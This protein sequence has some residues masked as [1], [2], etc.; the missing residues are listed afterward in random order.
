MTTISNKILDYIAKRGAEDR[1]IDLSTVF[2]GTGLTYTVTSSNADVAAV[3]IEDGK[4]V[5]D[6]TDVLGHTD[7]KITATDANGHSMT[8]NV[9]VRVAGENAYTIAVLPDTQDYTNASREYIF[10]GMMNWLVDNKDSLDLQFVIH[11]GD[12]T[13][14]NSDTSHWP[15]AEPAI[16][17]LDGKIP[18]SLLPGNHDQNT[19]NAANWSTT[20]LDTRFSPDKQAATNPDTFGGVYDM[21]PNRSANNYHTFTAP[22]GTKWM[23]LSL[24]FG[25]RADV[26]RWADEVI[27]AH[28]DHRVILANH[29][30]MTWA[31]RHDATGAPLYDEGTGYDYGIGN[32]PMQ[33]TDGE[34]MYRQL[35]QKHSNVTFTFSGHIFGD[36][37]ETLKSHDQFG[38][39][40]YQMMVNYQNG[41]STEITGN[42]GQASGSNGGNGA[43]RLLT[44]DPDSGAVYTSTYFSAIDDYLDSVRGD[45]ELDRDGLTGPYR[46][47]EEVLYLDVGTPALVAIAKAGNDQVVTAEAGAD[48]AL[49]VLDGGRTLNPGADAGLDYVWTDAKGHVVATGATPSLDLTAG[50]HQFTLTV[51]DS[52]GRVST[53]AV[54]VIV[55][56]QNT[57]L[58]DNFNDGNATGWALPGPAVNVTTGTPASFGIAALPQAEGGP[59]AGN[60]TSVPA[61]SAAQ[62]M[63]MQP[64]SPVP[65]GT[66]VTSYT[67]AYDIL[68]PSTGGNWFSFFQ[69]DVTNGSDAELFLNKRG[70]TGG[71]GINSD[72]EGSFAYNAW[73]RVVFTITDRG[74]NDVLIDKY[75]NGVKVGDT[76]MTGS[77]AAR[78]AVDLSKGALLFADNDGETSQ[79][80]VSSF[81]FTDKVLTS[82]EIAALGGVKAGGILAEQPTPNSVQIDF[83]TPARAD[84]WGNA[85]VTAAQIGTSVGNFLVKGTAASRSTTE[86]G[87][88]L[89]EGRLFQQ[90][91]SA[92]NVLVWKGAGSQTWKDYEFEATLHATDNDGIGVVFYHQDPQNH[93][94]VALDAETNTRTL[95][96]V[97]NGVTTVLA[98]DNGG[99]PW[100]RDFQLKVVVAGNQISVFLDGNSLFGEV[101]DAAPLTGGTVGFYSN[102]QRSSQFDN[103]TVNKIALT[104]HAADIDRPVDLDGDGKV[105]VTL[106]AAGSYGLS[107]ITSF[108][109]TDANGNIVASGETVQVE[110]AAV[111]Q[112]LTLT[113]TDAAGKT[114]TDKI[115]IDAVSQDRVLLS[116][117]FSGADFAAWTIV[118]E[119]ES[120]GVG[121]DGKSSQWELR[122]GALVQL[123]DIKSRQLTWSGASNS[124]PWKKGWSPLGDGVNVLRKGTYAL[125][126]DPAA[127]DWK[128]YAVEATIQS[129]DNGALGLLFYY[130]DANNYYKLELDANGDYDRTP[131][132]GAGSLFQL[133]QVKNGVESYLNQF[134]AKYTPGK[135]L[136]LRV[137]VEA[138]KIQAYVDGLA[139]FAYAIEDHAQTKGTVGL[140]SWDSAGVKFDNVKVYDLSQD[141]MLPGDRE[142][143]VGTPGDDILTGTEGADLIQG[144]DGDDVITAGAGN[145]LVQGGAGDD[146]LDGGAGN[147][148]LFGGEGDDEL[149]GGV[150]DDLLSG[151]AGDDLLNGGA[152][153]DTADYSDD[154][155]GVR[156]DLARGEAS[157]E[158]SGE[159]ELVSIE[160]VIGGAGNDTLIGD[161][162]ANLLRGGAGNDVLNGG[163]GN[164][165]LDGGAGNDTIDGGEG[166]DVLDLSGATG[167]V[168]ADFAAGIVSGAGIG[169]DS[170]R[171]IE[172]LQFGAGNDVVTGGNGNEAFNGGAGD[173]K[174]GG[175]T[176]NDT[177]IGGE[178]NDT[179]DGGSGHDLIDGG[180]GNDVIK[181]GSG[182]DTIGG[183]DGDDLI[184]AGSGD[185]IV[186]G[187]A[188]NDTIDG[189]SGDDRIEGGAG[190][191]VLTGGSGKDSFVFAPGFGND[192]IADFRTTGSSADVL[193]FSSAIFADFDAAIAAAAQVGAAT[194]F[195]IDADTS[196]TLEGVK[197]SALAADDFRFV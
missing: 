97:Q 29:S 192:R 73:N 124:D 109:W 18:Y 184:D 10:K 115:T 110:L 26:L 39:P 175:G 63:I 191:D 44:I 7:L 61:L 137:E 76:V 107:D 179:L 53:D 8:D 9:R 165:T 46:G 19:G 17:I 89:P 196:L 116:D 85:S 197:L 66:V 123:S 122:D 38:N 84:V 5:I 71:I 22:D 95:V 2:A 45:G 182:N 42:A 72:Y 145:D 128:D 91:D 35:I 56:D 161:A 187:G 160:N 20:P 64:L 83:S 13:T 105:M 43:I 99:T 147:D 1:V 98:S 177:L 190:D 70:T 28:L 131:G 178:G 180:T 3:A 174:L 156:V 118:D 24:E 96:K 25:P 129:P 133:I 37:A 162:G 4:L 80:Y 49:V 60:V 189:G 62:G 169:T 152:G 141:S 142:L 163:A 15:Y 157:G 125:F 41:V 135:E 51:T 94:R 36:G 101:T 181:A 52:A 186:L 132:N 16:R 168:M 92:G 120:G 69:T 130:Q 103:A 167:P 11:V 170:F 79:A 12:I 113:V 195:T 185:D 121:P 158:Q 183:G 193:E 68:V 127:K 148:S 166:F 104:A 112:I 150:G 143:I 58:V 159:D 144:M 65:A 119:G 59:V 188:G 67:L 6:Y 81:L 50:Q 90:S 33:A 164:D 21:E 126:N 87:Q 108:V 74:N 136:N 155:A 78:Y 75:I 93:Y 114:A 154:T 88:A 55:A 134:P 106:D 100:S 23:V 140:F 48:S 32:N 102:N 27:E 146:L 151:G 172:L 153:T 14:N 117:D 40:V 138:G 171:N 149:L 173:D 194:V 77:N 86:D 47:H 82:A 34:T 139:L 111:Q 54:H 31:G 30:Y 57:L 176:G